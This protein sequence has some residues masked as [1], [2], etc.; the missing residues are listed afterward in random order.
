MAGL[1][2]VETSY[3]RRKLH[4]GYRVATLRADG[5]LGGMGQQLV[6]HEFHYASIT[7]DE[8]EPALAD[9]TD[10]EGAALGPAGHRIGQVSG[11]FFHA[12]ARR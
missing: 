9:V 5:V 4:L 11:T 1:L 12:V 10:A 7:S 2:P 6:G 3:A 8:P